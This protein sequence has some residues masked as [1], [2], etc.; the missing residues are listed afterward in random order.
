MEIYYTHN[1]Y[2]LYACLVW[3]VCGCVVCVFELFAHFDA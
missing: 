3:R 1:N 2:I